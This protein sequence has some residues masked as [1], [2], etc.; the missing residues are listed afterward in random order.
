MAR[1]TTA[2]STGSLRT[3]RTRTA[4]LGGRLRD[5][6]PSRAANEL[7]ES[8]APGRHPLVGR[9][10]LFGVAVGPSTA[11][12]GQAAVTNG[13]PVRVGLGD[14]FVADDVRHPEGTSPWQSL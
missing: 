3:T 10:G 6:G 5:A 7:L 4:G 14:A 1:A 11:V 8:D 2:G 13:L 9:V 12:D